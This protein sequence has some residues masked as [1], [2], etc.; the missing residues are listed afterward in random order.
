MKA[1]ELALRW[2]DEIPIGIFYQGTRKSYESENEV[3]AGGTL[4][5]NYFN[6]SA[7][8][9]KEESVAK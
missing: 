7:G 4:T 3:L 9:K 5:G 2:G 8:E 6:Q 1:L